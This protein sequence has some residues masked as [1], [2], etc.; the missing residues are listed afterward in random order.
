MVLDVPRVLWNIFSEVFRILKFM[1]GSSGRI[2]SSYSN[3]NIFL[4]Q[5]IQFQL[6]ILGSLV[7]INQYHIV[8]K[9]LVQ[10]NIFF[11]HM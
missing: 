3:N 11:S 9:I 1:Q 7:Y 2:S 8:Y 5:K 4:Q 10:E 6:K